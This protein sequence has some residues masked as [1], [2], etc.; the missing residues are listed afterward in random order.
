MIPRPKFRFV[1]WWTDRLLCGPL[2]QVEQLFFPP[3][4][5]VHELF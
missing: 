4:V 2:F 3:K 1:L 5:S